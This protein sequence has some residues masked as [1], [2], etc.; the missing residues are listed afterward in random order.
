M[1]SEVE[2]FKCVSK[3]KPN[4]ITLNQDE[5]RTIQPTQLPPLEYSQSTPTP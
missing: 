1:S 3:V 4:A 5:A 2:E